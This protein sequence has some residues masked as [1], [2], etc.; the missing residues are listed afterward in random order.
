[1]SWAREV[2]STTE[3]LS[4]GGGEENSPKIEQQKR[5]SSSD[6]GKGGNIVAEVEGGRFRRLIPVGIKG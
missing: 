6:K 2:G 5:G 4:G 1:M 3:A